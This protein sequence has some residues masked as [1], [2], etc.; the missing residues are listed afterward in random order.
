VS[1]F[2]VSTSLLG[3]PVLSSLLAAVLFAQIPSHLS[4]LGIPLVFAGIIIAAWA[5][6]NRAS[7]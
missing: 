2:L 6:G 5:S 3:E 7:G 1:A 4:L